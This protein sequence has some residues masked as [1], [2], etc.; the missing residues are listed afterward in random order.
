MTAPRPI[1]PLP[2]TPAEESERGLRTGLSA[3]ILIAASIVVG[4][5][6]A[7]T[8]ALEEHLSG[9]TIRAWWLAGFSVLSFV[10]MSFVIGIEPPN[11]KRLRPPP[12]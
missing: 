7:L 8:V 12:G 5:L 9:H 1:R 10:V 4:Q 3:R 11:R 2:G 6:W